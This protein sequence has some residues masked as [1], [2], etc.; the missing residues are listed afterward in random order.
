MPD[1]VKTATVSPTAHISAIRLNLV[2]QP[3]ANRLKSCNFSPW[4][5][6]CL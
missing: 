6:A 5:A 2:R 4:Q 1:N 3:P